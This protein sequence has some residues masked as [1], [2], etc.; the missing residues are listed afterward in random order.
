MVIAPAGRRAQTKELAVL[1]LLY[2]LQTI[3]AE[4]LRRAA[5]SLDSQLTGTAGGRI[6]ADLTL[7]QADR[8]HPV[9]MVI[10]GVG[11]VAMTTA[12]WRGFRVPRWSF[13]ALGAWFCL[14]LLAEY[15]TINGLIFESS[16][17]QPGVLLG[18]IV[19]YLP[20]FMI[21]W[22][23]IFHRLDLVG[24]AQPGLV[25]QLSDANPTKGITSFDYYHASI[26]TLLNKGKPTLV[27]VTRTGRILV[28]VYL[29]M[30]LGLY[31][32]TF[33]RILQLTRSL[34]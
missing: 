28:L 33:A 2:L 24:Q 13:D 25:V 23:W 12:L 16:K 3:N 8:V 30:I 4:M 32:L 22:G 29:G 19:L 15:L 18:Q 20:Y 10:C 27:G 1:G 7:L 9:A 14:R 21:S 6:V 26:S 31:A 5:G 11:L 17:V 34:V